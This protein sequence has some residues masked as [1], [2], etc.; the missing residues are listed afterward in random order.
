[1]KKFFALFL[2]FFCL[3]FVKSPFSLSTL[4]QNYDA[5]HT[6][7]STQ[8]VEDE[9]MSVIKNGN[10]FLISTNSQNAAKIKKKMQASNLQGESFC[11]DGSHAKV[12][13]ILYR[14]NAKILFEEHFENFH[15]IYAHTKKI[16]KFVL[17]NSEKINL[18]IAYKNEKITVG[19]PLILGS[20]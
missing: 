14:A 4:S 12:F 8:K 11:F 9:N 1:M 19:T 16:H 20:Y 7:Y 2:I 13:E 15:I 6:F 3:L 18:Q 17:I 10:G 5:T